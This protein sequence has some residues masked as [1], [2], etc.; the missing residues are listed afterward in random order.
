MLPELQANIG[1]R[2][3][4]MKAWKKMFGL[5][6]GIALCAG[7]WFLGTLSAA[8]PNGAAGW[9]PAAFLF[10]TGIYLLA[11]VVRSRLA[12]DGNRIE[13]QTAFTNRSADRSQIEG[14]RTIQS[15]NGSYKQFQLR[16]GAGYLTV[17][18]DFDTDADFD[19]WM[20]PIPDLDLRDREA[21][22]DTIKQD[23]EL[24]ATP[25]DR[26]KAL[27]TAK[28]LSIFSLVVV[29]AA[30]I[31]F[32][33]A[34]PSIQIPAGIV[35]ALAPAAILMMVSRA[36]MLYAVFK[37][38]KDPRAELAFVLMVIGFSFLIRIAGIHVVTLTS[39]LPI[40][41]ILAIFFLLPVF[42]SNR[43][44]PNLF[45]R[46]IGVILF[47]GLYGYGLT[48]AADALLDQ[49]AV[50]PFRATV[51]DKHESHGRSTSYTLDLAPWGPVE[52]TNKI[53]VSASVYAHTYIG[54]EVCL[55]L[56]PGTLHVPWY[57]RVECSS[58]PYYGPMP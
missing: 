45:G 49:G 21:L 28:T 48:I 42:L 37:P 5:L 19:A 15:R 54:D 38:K 30:A 13:V 10:A 8:K 55:S 29:I 4:P 56:H 34:D 52:T 36:P 58:Q 2:E 16:D 50:S 51:V 24:G 14:Y 40:M 18:D 46:I 1:R 11:W 6:F 12:V 3:F 27:A 57:Q 7:S 25:E 31:A 17:R 23:A 53:G 39:L 26:L 44:G 32:N 41:A 22:L 33:F 47:A 20:R 9:L 43:G 35:L